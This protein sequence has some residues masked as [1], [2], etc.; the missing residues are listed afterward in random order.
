AYSF[1]GGS[2]MLLGDRAYVGLGQYRTLFACENYLQP[3]T[4]RQ[5]LF[6][7][8]VGNT[9]FFVVVQV[10]AMVLCAVIT[11]LVLNREMRARGFW[12]AVFFFP[13]LLSPVVVALIWKWILQRDG[14]LNALMMSLGYERTLWLAE[15]GWAM[16]WAI[17]VS[18]WAHLGFYTL[19]VLAGL[20]AIPADLYQAAEMAG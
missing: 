3:A 1:T 12:R 20:Q 19:I 4:C 16:F 7:T 8:A 6:W 5:D 11:A 10:A 9:G 13:V 2:A 17:F 18:T 15:R 14:A